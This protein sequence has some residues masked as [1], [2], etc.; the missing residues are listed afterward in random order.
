MKDWNMFWKKMGVSSISI[1]GLTEEE[2]YQISLTGD[3]GF[4]IVFEISR[5]KVRSFAGTT[6]HINYTM[7]IAP[8]A[9]DKALEN[10]AE[11]DFGSG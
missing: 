7:K 5:E 4:K 3:G 11:I 1:S 2:D 6:M 8:D 10:K 9:A